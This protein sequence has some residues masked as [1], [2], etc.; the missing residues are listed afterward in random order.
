M[1]RKYLEYKEQ[2]TTVTA[3]TIYTLLDTCKILP[4]N[5]STIL[6][7]TK[8]IYYENNSNTILPKTG[9]LKN[10]LYRIIKGD[11]I[12]NIILLHLTTGIF[13]ILNIDSNDNYEIY[14]T[15]LSS[16]NIGKDS[17]DEE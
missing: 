17:V 11:G 4:S 5:V 13:Y 9:V 14:T 8:D 15:Y 1:D 16:N 7:L 10:G 6:K 2:V 12:T 3:S